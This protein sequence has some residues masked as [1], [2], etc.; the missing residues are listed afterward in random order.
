M[1]RIFTRLAEATHFLA[2]AVETKNNEA[3][4]SASRTA[5]PPS[6]V[7]DRLRERNDATPLVELYAGREFPLDQD[8]F[9][10]GGHAK[11]LGHIHIDFVRSAGGWEVEQIWMCR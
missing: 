4:A 3:L 8:E 10:L 1:M 7:I 5:L 11:E 2:Q 6:W 9:K